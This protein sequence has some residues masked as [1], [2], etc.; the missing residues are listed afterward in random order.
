MTHAGKLS[1][2]DTIE[3]KGDLTGAAHAISM[4]AARH[5]SGQTPIS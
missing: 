3:V 1:E 2:N 4:A 5:P